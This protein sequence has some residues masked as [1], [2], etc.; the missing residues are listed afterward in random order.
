MDRRKLA[1][2]R[3]EREVGQK[4]SSSAQCPVLWDWA[5]LLWPHSGKKAQKGSGAGKRL[6][7]DGPEQG[8]ESE[9]A[10]GSH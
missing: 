7:R 9:G 10:K 2:R 8:N 6:K 4:K 3:S 1:E 5:A